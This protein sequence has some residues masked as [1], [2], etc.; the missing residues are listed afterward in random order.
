MK[1]PPPLVRRSVKQRRLSREEVALWRHVVADVTPRPGRRSQDLHSQELH[2]PDVAPPPAPASPEPPRR[3]KLPPYV[4]APPKPNQH[5]PLAPLDKKLK[6]KLGSGRLG[7]DDALDLH[8]MT[9]TEA[10]R[11]LNGFLW[12]AAEN[13][14]RLVLIVTGKGGADHAGE[15]GVLRRMTPLWLREKNLRP[16]ILSIE[17]AGRFHGGAGALYVRLRRRG[18]NS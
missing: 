6:R 2:S 4:P 11:A 7:V 18:E 8:G 9:Q 13:G 16:L 3:I 1:S 12:R 5:P 14:C 10:H 15:R 17:E